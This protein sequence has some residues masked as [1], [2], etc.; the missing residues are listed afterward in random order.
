MAV[1]LSMLAGAGAQF[2]TDSGVPLSGGLIYTYAA[3]TTTPQAAYTSSSGSTAHSN[4]IVLNS[5][6]R[7]AS[8]GEIW[9][10]DA[11]SYKFVLQTSA[12]VTIATYDNVTGNSSGIYAAFA[13]SSGSSLVG[14]IQ[15][16]TGSVATTVQAK[17]RESVSVADFGATG[18][19]TTDD[20]AAIQAAINS[21]ANKIY[22]PAGRY[23]TTQTIKAISTQAA[24]L[25]IYGEGAKATIISFEPGSYTGYTNDTALWF[26][27]STQ[28]VPSTLYECRNLTLEDFAVYVNTNARVALRLRETVRTACK[29]LYLGAES[30]GVLNDVTCLVIDAGID[31]LFEQVDCAPNSGY[32]SGSTLPILALTGAN[33]LTLDRTAGS[34]SGAAFTSSAFNSCYFHVANQIGN[35]SANQVAFNNCIFESANT[36]IVAGSGSFNIEFI[37]CYYESIN[38]FAVVAAGIDSRVT[39]NIVVQGGYYQM[40]LKSGYSGSGGFVNAR[41]AGKVKVTD[42]QIQS[43]GPALGRAV[44]TTGYTHSILLDANYYQLNSSTNNFT[45]V[46]LTNVLETVNGSPDLILNYTGHGLLFEDT[47]SLSGFTTPLNNVLPNQPLWRVSEVVSANQVKLRSLYGDINANASASGL[48]GTG[49]FEK[50]LSTFAANFIIDVPQATKILDA[51]EHWLSFGR[52]YVAGADDQPMYLNS[53]SATERYVTTS[54]C[55]LMY[56]RRMQSKLQTVQPTN[57]S[58]IYLDLPTGYEQ[59]FSLGGPGQIPI[60]TYQTSNFEI[61]RK[62]PP[63]T[64]IRV[65]NWLQ[66]GVV[67]YDYTQTQTLQLLLVECNERLSVI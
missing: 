1:N 12:A 41:N 48:G 2:F 64:V 66:G 29:R 25:Y 38:N 67:G 56:A 21:G 27:N 49:T 3:G 20:T 37:N 54:W 13:A 40:N 61:G 47:I 6:G 5:A 7:V 16:S 4:P 8:G 60:G 57:Y 55:Y 50:Y 23:R 65:R 62:I 26:G 58:Y 44:T 32:D 9:L 24:P 31:C 42:V 46:S 18:N 39:S 17:L 11:V 53:D 28:N 22:L 30:F 45:P 34:G 36:G 52:N 43:Q 14:Y 35:I 33:S 59:N 19:G 10:T 15:G 63:G 51:K